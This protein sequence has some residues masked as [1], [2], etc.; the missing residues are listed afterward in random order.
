MGDAQLAGQQLRHLLR[1]DLLQLVHG[2]HNI[3]GLLTQLQHRIKSIEDLSVVHANLEP[4]QPQAGEGLKNNRRNLG[5]IGDI[6]LTVANNIN[7]RL[8]ELPEP[9]PLG[10]L[11]AVDLSD[12]EAAEGEGQLIIMER[13]ILRQGHGQIEAQGEVAVPLREP[14][15]LFFRL[16]AGLGQ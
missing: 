1:A 3:P 7:I 14:V 11:T 9:A 2:P 4:P 16:T 5:L 10:A 6:Q 13:D 12:L 8:I 15:N